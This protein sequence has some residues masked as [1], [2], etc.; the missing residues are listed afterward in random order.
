MT[1]HKSTLN[2][3]LSRIE[4]L[5]TNNKSHISKDNFSNL[6]FINSTLKKIQRDNTYDNDV[7]EF[8]TEVED[9]VLDIEDIADSLT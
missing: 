2:N 8:I 9:V 3:L 7:I 1:T 5:Y 4:I 6:K